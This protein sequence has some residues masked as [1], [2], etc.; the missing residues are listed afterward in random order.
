MRAARGVGAA[1]PKSQIRDRVLVYSPARRGT[2]PLH[3]R[4][5]KPAWSPPASP[6]ARDRSTTPRS[7]ENVPGHVIPILEREFDDF[8]TEAGKFLDGRDARGPVHRLPPEAG[9]LRP[10][11]GRRPDDPR[12]AALRRRHAR[13]DGRL[14]RR[15]S[16]AT[17]RCTRATSPRARTSRSTTSRCATPPRLIRDP[18]RRRPLLARGLR[19]H[20]A[21][22]HRR[23][24]GRRLRGRALRPH[25]LRRR[26]RALLRAPPD[27]CQLMP[28]KFKTAFTATDE[29]RAITGIH[30]LGFIPRVARRRARLRDARRRRHLD[31]AAHRADALR[32]RRGRRR[33]VPQGRRG[34]ASASSTART[35]CARTAPAPASRSSSTRSASTS[36]REMVEEELAGRLGRRARLRPDPLLFDRR[37]GGQR[38]GAARDYAPARTATAP[39]SSASSR[40]NVAPQRQDG[41][42]HRRR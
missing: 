8:D 3:P 5:R 10:A 17:R 9:R 35:G 32:V 16:S 13:A 29:D 25:P 4:P 12:Q 30:D 18:R 19:Q 26:V 38:P 1:A 28:R 41:F 36:F 20:R 34:R 22:R 7:V 27:V 39:S 37:R 31:H 21:Q 24:V 11:P 6:A 33:R 42:S 14:R 40:A 23:P 2:P 15:A